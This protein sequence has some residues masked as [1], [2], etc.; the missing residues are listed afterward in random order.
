MGLGDADGLAGH[1]GLVGPQLAALEEDAVGGDLVSRAEL[2]DV[3]HQN[4][5]G[6][7]R[8]DLAVADNL[9]GVVVLDAVELTELLLLDVVDVRLQ[10][11]DDEDDE[12]DGDALEVAVFLAVLLETRADAERDYRRDAQDLDRE[13][14]ERVPA[15]LQEALGRRILEL[16]DPER[17]L[18][19]SKILLGE[20]GSAQAQF[21]VRLELIGDAEV[22]ASLRDRI[23]IALRDSLLELGRGEFERHRVWLCAKEWKGRIRPI[24]VCYRVMPRL[25]LIY[26]ISV[27]ANMHNRPHN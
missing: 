3:A 8:V 11:D 20:L 13:I 2:Y 25:C 9:D 26:R 5:A 17:L 15:Q 4:L 23:L 18:A 19:L 7:H 16:V 14:I 22:A 21:R 1:R 24:F 12:N 6:G 27:W 10:E